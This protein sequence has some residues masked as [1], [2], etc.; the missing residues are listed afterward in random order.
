M[1][2]PKPVSKPSFHKHQ[3]ALAQ[4]ARCVAEKSRNAAATELLAEDDSGQ[5]AVTYDG[6]W[7]RRGY[8]SLNGVFTAIAWSTG[9]V[10]D[11][12]TSAKYCHQCAVWNAKLDKKSISTAQHEVW[13]SQH[14]EVCSANTIC[15]SPGME[16]EAAKILWC[17]SVAR[18]GLQY[19]TYIGDGDCKGHK[20]VCAAKPY[21][22][23]VVQ[24]EECVGHIQKRVGK[25]LRDIKKSM[26]GQKLSDGLT[27]GGVGRLTD[28]MI[29]KLQT[30]YG[31]AVRANSADLSKM[32]QG[33]WAGVLHR[34]STDAEPRHQYCPEGGDSWCGWQR[35]KAQTQDTY[36][37]HDVLPMAIFEVIRETYRRLTEPT[38]LRRCLMGAT[39]NANESFNG[40]VWCMCPK[41][42]NAGHGVVQL[43]ADLATITFNDGAIGLAQVL[44]EMEC[45]VG[46]STIA[47]LTQEDSTRV[48]LAESASSPVEKERRKKRRKKKKGWE[49]AKTT[50][51]GVTYE[52]GGF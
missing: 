29:D 51:E 9:K 15:S 3:K 40:V 20:E 27:T 21:G 45:D 7:Q 44:Q 8:S 1:D 23:L 19:V 52:P 37:H 39:Q 10:V 16:S 42:V 36:L 38:L 41:E 30:Y 14:V 13:Q 48:Q 25:A 11:V 2:L 18:R 32:A 22:D 35:V 5:I 28:K 12:H 24:K 33:I 4:A 47:A 6:T 43:A 49:E 17:R 50:Q 46:Q 26:K 31:L 34:C